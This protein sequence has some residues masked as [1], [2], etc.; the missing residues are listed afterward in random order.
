MDRGPYEMYTTEEL[1]FQKR[2]AFAQLLRNGVTTALPI[3]SLFYREWGE[4]TEEFVSAA[5]IAA[6]L[7]RPVS[8][9]QPGGECE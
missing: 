4:T 6:E 5:D 1:A 2:Y 9:R 3:S 7:G 8:Q